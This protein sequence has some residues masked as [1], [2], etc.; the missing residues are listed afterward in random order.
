VSLPLRLEVQAL[1]R[2]RPDADWFAHFVERSSGLGLGLGLTVLAGFAA[3]D[4]VVTPFSLTGFAGGRLPTH[5]A[6]ALRSR[7]LSDRLRRSPDVPRSLA[8]CAAAAIR[9]GPG[10]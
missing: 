5:L 4:P 2:V 6:G 8:R 3:S 1:V 7:L 9:A 10:L